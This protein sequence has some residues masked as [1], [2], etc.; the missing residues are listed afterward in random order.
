MNMDVVS[1]E[2]EALKV[3]IG[4][5]PLYKRL[6]QTYNAYSDKADINACNSLH[7]LSLVSFSV[8]LQRVICNDRT[9][10]ICV[11]SFYTAYY[12]QIKYNKY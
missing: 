2:Q 6:Y 10:S 3:R 7:V 12:A 9:R 5:S 1:K 4:Q 11:F 8:S